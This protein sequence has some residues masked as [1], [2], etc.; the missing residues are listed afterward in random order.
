MSLVYNRNN[1]HCGAILMSGYGCHADAE[2][3]SP[4]A[5]GTAYRCTKHKRPASRRLTAQEVA[6][7]IERGEFLERKKA[8]ADA[9]SWVKYLTDRRELAQMDAVIGSTTFENCIYYTAKRG[10]AR[11]EL[12]SRATI[13]LGSYGDSP[14]PPQVIDFQRGDAVNDSRLMSHVAYELSVFIRL[15]NDALDNTLVKAQD[16]LNAVLQKETKND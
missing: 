11:A 8:I 4:I 9:R 5:W 14:T 13:R 3:M 1:P 6:A 7:V 12:V 2:W 16:V 15:Y 10:G